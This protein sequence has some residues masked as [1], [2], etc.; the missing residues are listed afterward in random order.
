[1]QYILSDGCSFL[2]GDAVRVG[3]IGIEHLQT[4][5]PGKSESFL[6]GVNQFF[7]LLTIP[8]NFKSK[9]EGCK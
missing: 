4:V 3:I 9:I 1:M 2:A 8:G 6:F 5:Q 7:F